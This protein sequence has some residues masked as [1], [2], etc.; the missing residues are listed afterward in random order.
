MAFR[1]RAFRRVVEQLRAH[2]MVT[3]GERSDVTPELVQK[4]LEQCL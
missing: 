3:L 2:G 4:I 1:Q